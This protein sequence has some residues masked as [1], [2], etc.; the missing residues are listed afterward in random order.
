MSQPAPR[1]SF[2][3]LPTEIHQRIF[4]FVL[5]STTRYDAL[6]PSG[7]AEARRTAGALLLVDRT[8]Y[9]EMAH[10]LGEH[11]RRLTCCRGLS[12]NKCKQTQLLRYRILN[13]FDEWMTLGMPIPPAFPTPIHFLRQ[14][15]LKVK[16]F[17]RH[18]VETIDVYHAYSTL[19]VDLEEEL[20]DFQ[21]LEKRVREMLAKVK[22]GVLSAKFLHGILD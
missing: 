21:G 17:Q 12:L 14:P 7:R 22:F 15:F 13:E 2:D 1:A 19:V 9:A 3:D 4:R 18:L 5:A 10:V 6:E 11:C 8:T 20:E 16:Q